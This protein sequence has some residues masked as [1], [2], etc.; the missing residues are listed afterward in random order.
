MIGFVQSVHR[1]VSSGVFDINIIKSLVSDATSVQECEVLDFKLR[2]PVTAYEYA[3]LIRDLVA[4]HNSYGGF[5]VFGVGE[6]EKDRTFCFATEEPEP[7]NQAKVTDLIQN[8]AGNDIRIRV[9]SVYVN[10]KKLEIVW[11]GKRNKGDPPIKFKKNGSE[12]AVGK[13]CFKRGEVV[14]RRI[15]CNAVAQNADDYDF[16]YSARMPPS[17]DIANEEINNED[18]LNHNLPDRAVVCSKFVGRSTDLGK[19]WDW[20]S[21]DFSRV[22]LIAGEGGLGKT[23]LA[24][25][26]SEEI[27]RR[28]VRPFDQ[29]L[30]LTAKRRQFKPVMDSYELRKADFDDAA[31]LFK[32]IALAHGSIND[33]FVDRDL[34]DLT[35]I[36]LE[37][38]STFPSFIVVDDV[39]S[40]AHADQQRVLEFGMRT[41]S[42]TKM[43]LTTRVNFSYSPDN[44]LKLDGFEELEF[45]EYITVLRESYS[46]PKLKNPK[47]EHIRE[48]TGGSPLFADSLMR[49]ERRGTSL[50][51][52]IASWKGEKGLEAR[53]AA[54]QR[55]ILILTR[56]AKRSL[57][58]ISYV[59]N[60]SYVEL[61]RILEYAE[62]TLGDALQQLMGL[63]LI[64]APSIGKE[65]RYTVDSNTGRLVLEMSKDLGIDHSKL[66]ARIKRSGSDAIGQN[67][68]GRMAVVAQAI[69]QANA[70]LLDGKLKEAMDTILS[71][72]KK[73]SRPHPDLLL[74][75]GK[76]SLKLGPSNLSQASKYFLES[77][78]L[79]Q[80]KEL[81][82]ALWFETEMKRN[83]LSV[84][85][86]VTTMALDCPGFDAWYWLERRA[87]VQIALA[88]RASFNEPAHS[89][90]RIIDSAISD[91]RQA[92]EC[93]RGATQ[94]ERLDAVIKQA[95]N[96]RNSLTGRD[97]LNDSH[98]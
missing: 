56:E 31:S 29:V 15:S 85:L 46:L 50:D 8:Y 30:W 28:R 43:L 9:S 74:A 79:G 61:K 71:A 59:K 27:A 39:D 5:L 10:D 76:I 69:S 88:R 21:D 72:S 82:F 12:E 18:P 38:C 35:R 42:R 34:Q 64:S 19:L 16:L 89:T 68:Q 93:V 90:L 14:F 75:A 73:V 53:K 84:A 17:I 6:V 23:S 78:Q 83:D 97:L 20:L 54:L 92:R 33:D 57:F 91:L 37:S 98:N 32:A 41:P 96:F 65:A 48:V 81:L 51:Q 26:F 24:Y 67:I 55:E 80:R 95:Y 58:V 25:R 94:T 70:F 86:D 63:F 45:R 47:I 40:L 36:A 1:C 87:H 62:E 4:F 11:V 49:L 77:Y 22:R 66:E 60:I 2:S 13:P 52:A 44:L 7:V 3:K